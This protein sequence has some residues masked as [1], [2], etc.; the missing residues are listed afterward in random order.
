MVYLINTQGDH[1]KFWEAEIREN[2]GKIILWRKWGKIGVWGQEMNEEYPTRAEAQDK[3]KE[4]VQGKLTKV[5]K[6]NTSFYFGPFT[7]FFRDN[8]IDFQSLKSFYRIV[9]F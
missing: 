6:L 9:I 4:L 7:S 8:F 3:L 1:F 2:E 5:T